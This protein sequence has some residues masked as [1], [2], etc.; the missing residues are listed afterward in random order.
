MLIQ[1]ENIVYMFYMIAYIESYIDDYIS[2]NFLNFLR[3]I[4]STLFYN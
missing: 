3:R 1:V 4:S 2:I